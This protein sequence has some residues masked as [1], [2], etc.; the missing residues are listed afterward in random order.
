ML[1]LNL[2]LD[3]GSACNELWKLCTFWGL[4]GEAFLEIGNLTETKAEQKPGNVTQEPSCE[5]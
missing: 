5:G 1:P 2:R 4:L 3:G